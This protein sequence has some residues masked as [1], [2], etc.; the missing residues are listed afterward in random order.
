MHKVY[1]ALE[2]INI[3]SFP[4]TREVRGVYESVLDF[5]KD[6]EKDAKFDVEK[7]CIDGI[8]HYKYETEDFKTDPLIKTFSLHPRNIV[9]ES[10]VG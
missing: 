10:N 8:D 1:V 3:P 6:L 5:E 2:H 9:R 7:K 4:D